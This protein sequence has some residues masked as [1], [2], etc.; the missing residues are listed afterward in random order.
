[1]VVG[2]TNQYST[3]EMLAEVGITLYWTQ[4]VIRSSHQFVIRKLL[5]DIERV[6]LLRQ[7]RSFFSS[8]RA[9]T[10]AE[11]R[12]IQQALENIEENI[13]WMDKNLP[14]LKAW[15][16]RSADQHKN[17]ELWSTFTVN[18]WGVKKNVFDKNFGVLKRVILNFLN[19]G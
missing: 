4:Q 1:M 19:T 12:C 15:L 9:E 17:S 2:V 10:G 3:R 5:Y 16:H 18:V 11:L 13:R 7:V 8:L 14:L 6:S